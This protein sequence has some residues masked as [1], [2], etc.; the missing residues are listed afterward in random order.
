[1]PRPVLTAAAILGALLLAGC[2]EERKDP[3]DRKGALENAKDVEQV[4]K[5][6]A[7]LAKGRDPDDPAASLAADRA[8][9][10]LIARG[11]KVETKIIDT[12]RASPDWAVRLGCIE[13]L[14][15]IGTRASIEHLIAVLDD[16]EAL[17]A[18]HANVTLEQMLGVQQLPGGG[19]PG[20]AAL[21]KI[22]APDALDRDA[23]RRAWTEW[24]LRN[25]KELQRAWADWWNA[26]KAT[27]KI[28]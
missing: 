11:T 13:V 16:P 27:A 9:D 20:L 25:G 21:P 5:D 28:D 2:E 1:M 15:A 18:F 19:K 26:N 12:L 7:D 8:R 4:D 3:F 23:E 14:Q 24:H 10:A 6:L 17:V 22:P